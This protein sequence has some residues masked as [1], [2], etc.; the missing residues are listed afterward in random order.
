MNMNHLDDV[1]A[2]DLS[3]KAS[4]TAVPRKTP[5]GAMKKWDKKSI[6]KGGKRKYSEQ[7]EF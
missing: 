7:V 4:Q 1:V 6:S 3:C 5:K 2:V